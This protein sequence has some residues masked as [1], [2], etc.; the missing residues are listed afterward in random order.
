MK[1]AKYVVVGKVGSTYGV[2]GWLKI[3]SYTEWVDNILNFTPWYL[4]ENNEWKAFTVT[5]GKLH[6]K[7]MI[8]KFAGWDTPEKSRLLSGKK[9]AIVRS[10][11]PALEKDEYYWS[12]LEGLTVINQDGE[13]LGKVSYLI[14]TGSNDVLVIKGEK[15]FAI[16][17]L[18]PEVIK[19]IDLEKQVIHVDWELL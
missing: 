6:G 8:V 15:E 19:S 1:E 7:G 16:P 2:Q 9:I 11:L 10:Q 5:E 12:D 4:E 17:Y 18:L 14:S 13:V 3:Q